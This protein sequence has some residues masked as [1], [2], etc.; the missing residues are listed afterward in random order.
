M[1]CLHC[2]KRLSLLRKFSDGEFCSAE[3]RQVFQQQQSDLA[4]ARLLESQTR[5]E[6][7]LVK[8]EPKP[9]MRTRAAAVVEADQPV[10]EAGM[11]VERCKPVGRKQ[12]F[13]PRL[14]S[15]DPAMASEGPVC[16]LPLRK[17]G[18]PEAGELPAAALAAPRARVWRPVVYNPLFRLGIKLPLSPRP[19]APALALPAGAVVPLAAGAAPRGVPLPLFEETS[20][21]EWTPEACRPAFTLGTVAPERA[22]VPE[23]EPLQF[24]DQLMPLALPEPGAGAGLPISAV[25]PPMPARRDPVRGLAPGHRTER[26]GDEESEPLP[27]AETLYSVAAPGVERG[28]VLPVFDQAPPAE[29]WDAGWCEALPVRRAEAAARTLRSEQTLHPVAGPQAAAVAAA[30]FVPGMSALTAEVEPA[31][32]GPYGEPRRPKMR[33][34]RR[35]ARLKTMA[36]AAAAGIAAAPVQALPATA[37]PGKPRGPRVCGGT[38]PVVQQRLRPLNDGAAQDTPRALVSMEQP[39]EMVDAAAAPSVPAGG[40]HTEIPIP[41]VVV[42]EQAEDIVTSLEEELVVVRNVRPLLV[43]AEELASPAELEELAQIVDAVEAV[44][45]VEDVVSLPALEEAPAA[46]AVV[47][48][49]L[50]ALAEEPAAALEAFPPETTPVAVVAAEA[51][52][53]VVAEPPAL[54]NEEFTPVPPLCREIR[55]FAGRGEAGAGPTVRARASDDGEWMESLAQDPM[56]PKSSLV[57]DHADG[58]GAR[59]ATAEKPPRKSGGLRLDLARLP[60]RRF[61]AHAPSDLKWVALALPVI[62]TLVVYSFK[63]SPPKSEAGRPVAANPRTHSVIGSELNQ[64]QKVILDRAAIK[65]YDDFRGGLGSWQGTEGW[66][67]SWKYG[68]AS[69]LEPGQLALYSPTVNMRDYTM[70]FLGQIERRSLNWVFRAADNR[71]YYAMRIVITRA[72]P[73]PQA[74]VVRYAVI[75]GKETGTKT[76]PLPFPVHSDTLYLVK[77]EVRGDSFITYIQNQVVDNF[78]DSRLASGGVGFFSP[79]GDKSY[80]RWVEVTHQYDALGRLCAFLAPYNVQAEGRKTE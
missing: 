41:V 9:A 55:I 10:P 11:L 26:V 52:P 23:P 43:T 28:P 48:V 58:S 66:A 68:E 80:L 25:P 17:N 76:L 67:K 69:F 5:I 16:L 49:A 6:K 72:G 22:E 35:S 15:L 60:G 70:Q 74:S 56:R 30:L 21:A 19:E 73:L 62:L 31:V 40:F 33:Q 59:R 34:M 54:E 63:A 8:P 45:P 57:I 78:S 61:W 37:E 46:E 47:P 20:L 3:H 51:E 39:V 24:I 38:A 29:R 7:P 65:L 27:M 53:P 1:R 12:I 32:P 64:I 4:L 50:E 79:K 77:M 2:G 14:H 71:N 75:N 18:F 44:S 13:V 42:P 36:Q